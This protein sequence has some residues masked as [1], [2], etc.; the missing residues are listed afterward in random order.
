MVSKMGQRAAVIPKSSQGTQR[1]IRLKIDVP[2]MLVTITLVV[3]GALMVFSA[4]WDVSFYVS[5]TNS[6][7]EM[8]NRQ[9]MWLGIGLLG[10]IA[11]AIIDYHIWQ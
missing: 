2:L 3:L 5:E 1:S 11:L 6:P 7:T 8:F 4:S 10:M 9:L